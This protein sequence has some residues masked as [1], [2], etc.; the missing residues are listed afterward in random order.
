MGR[1][2]GLYIL[3]KRQMSCL[4]HVELHFIGSAHLSPGLYRLSHLGSVAVAVGAL[5]VLCSD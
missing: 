2:V 1:S 3:E 4:L 5:T